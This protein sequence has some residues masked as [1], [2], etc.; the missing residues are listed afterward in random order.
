MSIRPNTNTNTSSI[1]H[2]TN[3]KNLSML[4]ELLLDELQ[5][6]PNSTTI[7]Q[8]I[9]TVFDGN[10]NLFKTRA[11]PNAGLMNLNKQFLNQL[12][13]A[14]NQLFPNLKQE[15]QLLQ[16]QQQMKRINISEEVL[17]DEPYKVEDIHNARQ[18]D[19]EKQ[20]LNKRNEFEKTINAKKPQPIDFSDKVEPDA[21]ITEMESLIAETMAKRKYEIEQLQGQGQGQGQEPVTKLSTKKTEKNVSFSDNI[22]YKHIEDNEDNGD[23]QFKEESNINMNNIF[24]KLKKNQSVIQKQSNNEYQLE[25]EKEK[26]YYKITNEIQILEGKIDKISRQLDTMMEQILNLKS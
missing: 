8:N 18:T 22:T 7:V 12:L 21:K 5:I 2:F 9:K 11:N 16:Q 15:Q 23:N 13:I 14:V 20:F 17:L 26:E 25:K 10:I 6:N 24:S 1:Q 3:P 19:F 4:W